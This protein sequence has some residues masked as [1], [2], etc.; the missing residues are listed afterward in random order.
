[1][2]AIPSSIARVSNMMASRMALG[3]IS[4][5]NVAMLNIQQ[6]ITLGRSILRPSDDVVKSSAIAALDDRLELSAQRKRNFSHATAALG[7]LDNALNEAT[8]LALQAKG[9][10]S[11][12]MAPT[13]SAAERSGQA[14]VVDEM[15]RSLFNTASTQGVAGYVFGGSRTSLPPVEQHLG[16]YR[17][18]SDGPGLVTDL[19]VSS[20]IPLTLGAG[21]PVVSTST[22]VRGALD[23][24]PQ[25]R[26]QTLLAD[27]DGARGLGISP[28]TVQLSINSG[29]PI[30]VDLADAATVDDVVTRITNAIRAYETD[31]SVTVLGPGAVNVSGER[32]YIEAA[33]GS[34][35]QFFD[36]GQGTTGADL[37][38]VTNPATVYDGVATVG[39]DTR[40]RLTL[41]TP[42]S[43]LDGVVG[44]LGSIRISNAGHSMIVDLSTATTLED[45]KNA[46]EGTNLGVRVQINSTGDGIDVI[47]DLATSSSQSLS[48]EEVGGNSQT[49]TRLGIR[50][51]A[52]TTRVS[53][54]NFGSGVEIIDQATNP[55]TGLPDPTLSA[56]FTIRLGDGAGSLISIDLRPQDMGTVQSVLDRINSEIANQLPSLGY[57]V[58]MV[59][60]FLGDNSNGIQIQ[61]DASFTNPLAVAKVNN[62]PAAEQ[63]GLTTGSYDAASGTLTGQDRAKIRVDGLFSDLLDLREALRTNDSVGIAVAGE[64][65]EA[66]IGALAETRGLVGSFAARVDSANTREEDRA[67][68]D[69]TVR[70]Q[71]RD[72]DY[73]EAASRFSLLQ[74]Q[75]QAA[76]QTT[77][78]YQSQSLLD[79]LG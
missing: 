49:A 14:I 23:L 57:S 70:S 18:V 12:Q 40:P 30:D 78:M 20:S 7:V 10:A 41:D 67:L 64:R 31:N 61:Q 76:L 25:L 13:S 11:D 19:G 58:G 72:V 21:N 43:A 27:L 38:L 22:R 35:V 28:G 8:D 55:V 44:A 29:T 48:I 45:I 42:V 52:A 69:E 56:D 6:Q 54:F 32:I 4:R 74:T 37:G 65:V 71:M 75:L 79:F 50:S 36:I 47:N 66:T 59:T 53:D 60:A 73:A 51:F 46:I 39:A 3:Q 5:T 62:S 2:S 33:A 16:G 15:L 1:M 17:F 77:A 24:N 26:L 68:I 63:L 34:S 9:I